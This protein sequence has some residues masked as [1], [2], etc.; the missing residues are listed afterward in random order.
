MSPKANQEIVIETTDASFMDW[1]PDAIGCFG[2]VVILI[3][4]LLLQTRK[5]SPHSFLFSILNVVG[6]LM[7]I[8]SLLYDWNLAAAFME[9]SWVIISAYGVFKIFYPRGFKG[10]RRKLTKRSA[11]FHLQS[12]TEKNFLSRTDLP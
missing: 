5:I 2:T 11:D 7:I 3:A 10:R 4:Y 9:V 8:I 1:F 12:N 6:G